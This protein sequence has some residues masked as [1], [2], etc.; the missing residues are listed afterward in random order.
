MGKKEDQAAKRRDEQTE[1]F[2]A[3]LVTILQYLAAPGGGAEPLWAKRLLA[4]DMTAILAAIDS[5]IA[6]GFTAPPD[7]ATELEQL[8]QLAELERE[9]Y[10]SVLQDMERFVK[11]Y[12]AGDTAVEQ[13]T[14]V[15]EV[16]NRT[17]VTRGI[18][19]RET[20]AE[21]RRRAEEAQQAAQADQFFR[22]AT[23]AGLLTAETTAED[24]QRL[25]GRLKEVRQSFDEQQGLGT[26]PSWDDLVQTEIVNYGFTGGPPESL[27]EQELRRAVVQERQQ[28]LETG[29]SVEQHRGQEAAYQQEQADFGAPVPS[30]AELVEGKR[31]FGTP[32]EQ[33]IAQEQQRQA[34]EQGEAAAYNARR[35]AMTPEEISAENADD[36]QRELQLTGRQVASEFAA[37]TPPS[38]DRDMF[39]R[40]LQNRQ[41]DLQN[42]FMSR[43]LETMQNAPRNMPI[44]Q[45]PGSY[46]G[47]LR[48]EAGGVYQQEMLRKQKEAQRK[49]EEQ[50]RGILTSK[51]PSLIFR[52]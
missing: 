15:L 47:F 4:L 37:E 32:A 23:L 51:K 38:D 14:T 5:E 36:Y 46:A 41:P 31:L 2:H 7:T 29:V 33:L 3:A 30:E 12:E 42:A 48:R 24:R 40:F 43:Q 19:E 13:T 26:A 34:G 50:Q 22:A 8:A 16:I 17:G 25:I 10:R 9:A 20:P 27:E 18:I 28:A 1:K 45:S 52:S 21:Q 39:L 11:A 49:A 44:D 6:A 35:A